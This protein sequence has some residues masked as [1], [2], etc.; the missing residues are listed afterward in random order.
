MDNLTNPIGKYNHRVGYV[1]ALDFADVQLMNEVKEATV[2]WSYW[3][4]LEEL[5]DTL[6]QGSTSR[7]IN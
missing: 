3:S 1:M 7:E 6:K 2:Y 5:S 4:L